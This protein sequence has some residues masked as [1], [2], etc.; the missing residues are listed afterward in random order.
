[1]NKH[2]S[3]VKTYRNVDIFVTRLHPQTT[4]GELLNCVDEVK[5]DLHVHD[6]KCTK[7]KSRYEGLYA[8]YY[9]SV[10]VDANDLKRAIDVFLSAD[11]WPI[12]VLV[13]RYFLP[14]DGQ[15]QE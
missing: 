15:G 10:K 8:S 9:V 7:L 2:I 11:V 1:M 5:G 6:T 4:A 14:K 3:A 12:G 13:R